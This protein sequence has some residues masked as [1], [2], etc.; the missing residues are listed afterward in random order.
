MKNEYVGYSREDR[1]LLIELKTT[2][3]ALRQDIFTIKDG[4]SATVTDHETRMRVLERSVDVVAA[5]KT[6]SDK[7]TR[8]GGSVLIVLVGIVEFVLTRYFK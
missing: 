6:A 5:E 2:V 3:G 4:I 7:F 1:D 8:L